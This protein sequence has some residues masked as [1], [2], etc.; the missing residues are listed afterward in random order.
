MNARAVPII[1]VDGKRLNGF[2]EKACLA[3][4]EG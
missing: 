4:Y 1:L 2:S 3:L